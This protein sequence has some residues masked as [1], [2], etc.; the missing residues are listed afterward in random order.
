MKVLK[1]GTILLFLGISG[2]ASVAERVTDLIPSLQRCD[3]LSY[4]RNGKVSE[5]P[6]VVQIVCR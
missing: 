2:C 5:G 4:Y 1:L 3:E 6:F